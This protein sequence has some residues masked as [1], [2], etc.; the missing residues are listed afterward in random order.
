MLFRS[1]TSYHEEQLVTADRLRQLENIQLTETFPDTEEIS[2]QL[3]EIRRMI[4]IK[5]EKI[6]G[7]QE[8]KIS[9]QKIYDECL[10]IYHTSQTKLDELTQLQQLSQTFNGENPKKTSLERY[11]LQVYLQEVLQVANDHLQ[12]LTKNRYQFEIGRAHV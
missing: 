12:R 11:V 5:Q 4:E 1:V 8:Q 7:L 6:Y 10:S 2:Q 9:N 3:E